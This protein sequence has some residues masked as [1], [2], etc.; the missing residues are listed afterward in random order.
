MAQNRTIEARTK[1]TA[2]NGRNAVKLSPEQ[3]RHVRARRCTRACTQG[4]VPT[5]THERTREP[6]SPEL[7]PYIDAIWETY[8]L[9]PVQ[10]DKAVSVPT[11]EASR[12]VPIHQ[13][14]RTQG[15]QAGA[16]CAY[17][18]TPGPGPGRNRSA[19]AVPKAT[20]LAV[21]DQPNWTPHSSTVGT[22]V[23]LPPMRV[24]ESPIFLPIKTKKNLPFRYELAFSF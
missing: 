24:G 16:G 19:G 11:M 1:K 18:P 12:A 23:P 20:R 13:G 3:Q 2:T 17:T 8:Q 14:T 21:P 7:S 5:Y 22:T 6:E 15:H 4:L 10:I 9:F